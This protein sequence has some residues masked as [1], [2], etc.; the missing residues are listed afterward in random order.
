M[1][2]T[3][4]EEDVLKLDQLISDMNKWQAPIKMHGAI[5]E[6]KGA[7]EDDIIID[8]TL[9]VPTEIDIFSIIGMKRKKQ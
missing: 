2:T 5:Y 6:T 4:I 1:V 3:T 9:N 7:E 8:Q